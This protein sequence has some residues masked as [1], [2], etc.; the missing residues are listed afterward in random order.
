MPGRPAGSEQNDCD[1]RRENGEGK[2]AKL[3]V[4]QGGIAGKLLTVIHNPASLFFI[5]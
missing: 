1:E 2:A 5:L 4:G 3:S